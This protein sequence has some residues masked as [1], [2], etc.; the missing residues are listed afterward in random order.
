[1]LIIVLVISVNT[2]EQERP[3]Y[4]GFTGLSWG[5]GFV[6]GPAIGGAFAESSATWRWAFYINLVLFGFFGPI[7]VF[8]VPGWDP[9]KG[10]NLSFL[11]RG[12]NMDW[13]GSVLEIGACVSGVMAISFGGTIYLWGSG[14]TI[15]LFVTSGVLFILFAFQ[16]TLC[17][18]TTPEERIFP[19][20]FARNR[21]MLMLWLATAAVSSSVL[22]GPDDGVEK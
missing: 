13:V 3:K 15:G 5:V 12:K 18:W 21:D 6:L 19:V 8:L 2:S 9:R 17:I 16:Q 1:V 22:V 11:S 4:M 10:Q 20:Q 7:I 14:Q